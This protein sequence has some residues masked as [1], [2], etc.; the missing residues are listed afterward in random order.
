MFKSLNIFLCANSP[1]LP[2]KKFIWDVWYLV[3]KFLPEFIKHIYNILNSPIWWFIF[4]WNTQTGWYC[5][6]GHRFIHSKD[7]EN[8]RAKGE[9][10]FNALRIISVLFLISTRKS[11][12]RV[13]LRSFFLLSFVNWEQRRLYCNKE[14]AA[15]STCCAVPYQLSQLWFVFYSHNFARSL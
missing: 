5:S 8:K 10:G 11:S 6:P 9:K 13:D 7:K 2:N 1:T 4:L 12:F 14:A 3:N 15:T